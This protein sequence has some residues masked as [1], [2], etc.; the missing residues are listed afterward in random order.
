MISSNQETGEEIHCAGP[1]NLSHKTP[2]TPKFL[3]IRPMEE[4][5]NISAKDQQED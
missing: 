3:I 5:K 2:G 1:R 4:N